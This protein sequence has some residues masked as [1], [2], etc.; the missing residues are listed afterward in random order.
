MTLQNLEFALE[1]NGVM[2]K[3]IERIIAKSKK[4]GILCE[5]ID[6]ELVEL[7]YDRIFA[8][9]SED[10]WDDDDFGYIEKFPHRHKF[11]EDY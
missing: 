9:E 5:A 8:T 1:L 4:N 10:S 2:S 6:D 11:L 3:D 7:G